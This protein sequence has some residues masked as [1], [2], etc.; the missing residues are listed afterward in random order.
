MRKLR[1]NYGEPLNTELL[2]IIKEV[3]KVQEG[4]E[5]PPGPTGPPGADAPTD[6]PIPHMYIDGIF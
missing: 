2:N 4:K 3:D 6:E 5:G 1:N